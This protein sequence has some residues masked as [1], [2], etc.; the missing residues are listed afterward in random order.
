MISIAAETHP[1]HEPHIVGYTGPRRKVL[2]V[3]DNVNNRQ[4]LISLLQP[5]G[6]EL[7]EASNGQAALEQARDW[8]PDL[9]LMDMFMPIMTGFD[10]ARAIRQ[11]AELAGTIIIGVSA[12][13]AESDT[14]R[15]LEAG[16]D[17]A[18]PKPVDVNQLLAA[19]KTHL[20]LTWI[21]DETTEAPTVEAKRE[22]ILPPAAESG[23]SVRS[24]PARQ[25]ARH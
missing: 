10:A 6:F 14:Q 22:I 25:P 16:C 4:V 12:S 3:D 5:L 20:D 21:Q 18:L 17:A 7:R 19:I 9:I 15:I 11:Q 1:D 13:V 8:R 23:D 24:R 2:V